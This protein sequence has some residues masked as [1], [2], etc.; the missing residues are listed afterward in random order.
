MI[1]EDKEDGALVAE[2]EV[3]EYLEAGSRIIRVNIEFSTDKFSTYAISYADAE[4]EQTETTET[5][6]NDENKDIVQTGDYIY[7]AIGA[8]LLVVVANV[9]YTVRKKRK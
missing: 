9:V 8:V 3:K 6:K 2:G 5:D 7:I 4:I 1:L